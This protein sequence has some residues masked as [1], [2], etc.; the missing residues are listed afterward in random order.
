MEQEEAGGEANRNVARIMA[1]L[2]ALA[3][4]ADQGLRLTDVM[5]AA[6]LNKTT[7]HRLLASLSPRP[8][9]SAPRERA[10]TLSACA[11]YRSPRPPSSASRL[12]RWSN[13]PWP[14]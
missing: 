7:A 4:A 14:I 11:C 13:R 12:R 8:R 2:D 3:H 5:R 6:G 10:A 9:R 1:I